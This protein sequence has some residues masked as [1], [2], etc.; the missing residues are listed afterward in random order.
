MTGATARRIGWAAVAASAVMSGAAVALIARSGPPTGTFEIVTPT[1]VGTQVAIGVAFLVFPAVGAIIVSRRPSHAIGWLFCAAGLA[2]GFANFASSYAYH[3]L[4]TNPG[5]L[6]GGDVL[7][8]VSDALWV[9]DLAATSVFLFLLF[10]TGVVHTRGERLTARF[11]VVAVLVAFVGGLVEPTLYAAPTISNPLPIR[12]SEAVAG[13]LESVGFFGLIGCLIASV[14]L[15]VRRFRRSSGEER[16]QMKWFV[17]AATFVFVLFVPSNVVDSPP[18]WL[19]LSAGLAVVSLPVS[20]AVAITNYRLYDID[21]VINKTVVYGA[22]AVFITV[23]YL[24]VVVGAGALVGS[25]DRPNVALSILATSIVAVAI[26]PMRT[27]LQRFANRVVYGK[28]ATP[29]EVL[30]EFSSRVGEGYDA[31][32]VLPRMANV[33]ASGTGARVATVWLRVGSETRP[34]ATWPPDA[35]PAAETVVEVRHRGEGLGALG[36]RM[37]ASD[38]MTPATLRLVEDLASQAGLVLRNV[39]LI[40]ELRASRQ[41]LVAAQDVERRKIERNLHDGAQQHLVALQV[42]VRLADRLVGQD[43]EK[44]HALLADVERGTADAL[45]ELRDLARGIYPPLLA[46]KGL[47]VALEAQARRSM[48]PVVVDASDAGRAPQEVEAAVYFSVLEALQNVAKYAQ[49]TKAEVVVRRVD[50]AIEFTVR[51]DGR[52][53][54]PDE[55]RYG[56][57]LQG[58]ADRIDALRGTFSVTSRPGVGTSVAGRIPVPGDASTSA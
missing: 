12:A 27:R 53:F 51:D 30:A 34:V 24:A 5:S 36:V 19:E 25:G 15:L 39:R 48:V 7:A 28:R 58:I 3:G 17:Y 29:Y 57:G 43:T 50:G 38:A 46:D 4:D 10:P 20:V 45:Q 42:K 11:A 32:D 56:T 33:L 26:Q 18:V 9:P 40:E 2:L 6:P 37:P 23:V 44:A 52:G 13:I 41:R 49:A 47:A 1:A 31:E 21:V 8:V 55:T 54:D 22:L 35:E 16:E 14:I